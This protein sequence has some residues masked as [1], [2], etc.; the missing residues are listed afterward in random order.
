M[1]LTRR[2]LA[3]ALALAFLIPMVG[4]CH[5]K[6]C[7]PSTTTFAPPG[8]CCGPAIPPGALPPGP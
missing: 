1:F 4:C 3:A 8:P 5:H 6:K 2:F 7:C